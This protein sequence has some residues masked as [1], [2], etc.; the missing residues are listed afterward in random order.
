[1]CV[2]LRSSP[3]QPESIIWIYDV[4]KV[5]RVL[6]FR[7]KTSKKAQGT[8]KVR[9]EIRSLNLAHRYSA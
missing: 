6:L 5:P 7:T 9:E 1:M 8:I 4:A 3:P 2:T